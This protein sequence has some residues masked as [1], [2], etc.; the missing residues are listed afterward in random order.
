MRPVLAL[1]DLEKQE[2]LHNDLRIVIILFVK[3]SDV[4][5]KQII[6]Q[7][8]FLNYFSGKYCTIYA[9]GYSTIDQ[10]KKYED[11]CEIKGT[12]NTTWYYSDKAL[13]NFINEI[14]ARLSSWVYENESSMILLQTQI[15]KPKA[16]NF[17]NCKYI[18]IA[19]GIRQG[20][21]DSFERF[22]AQL[23]EHT[24]RAVT[25]HDLDNQMITS[26]KLRDVLLMAIKD[27]KRIPKSARKIITD[28][29]FI[30]SSNVK[31]AKI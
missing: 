10:R 14:S 30:R 9:P 17:T 6:G 2:K 27:S 24:K 21:I 19:H 29:L 8:N 13:N 31:R 23:I 3:P 25:I 16:L 1:A 26:I 22:I 4:D 20:Y 5:G 12:N 11:M 7:F 18:E 28:K 15:D